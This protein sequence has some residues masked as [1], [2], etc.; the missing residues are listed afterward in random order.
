MP[1]EAANDHQVQYI[2]NP[3]QTSRE[4]MTVISVTHGTTL[5]SDYVHHLYNY[6]TV[7]GTDVCTK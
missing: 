5:P 4:L 3:A 1:D 6:P 7:Y 2:Y